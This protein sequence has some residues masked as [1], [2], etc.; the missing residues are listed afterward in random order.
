MKESKAQAKG[1]KEKKKTH[2]WDDGG[3]Y[4]LGRGV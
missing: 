2:V 4:V 3:R 1:K